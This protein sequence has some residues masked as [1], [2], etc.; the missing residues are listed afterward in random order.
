MYFDIHY[1][2]KFLRY[3]T[4]I[5]I[6]VGIVTVAVGVIL[7][8][9]ISL[10]DDSKYQAIRIVNGLKIINDSIFISGLALLCCGLIGFLTTKI[11]NDITVGLFACTSFIIFFSILLFT[12]GFI[13]LIFVNSINQSQ[14]NPCFHSDFFKN[15]ERVQNKAQRYYGSSY[16]KTNIQDMSQFVRDSEFRQLNLQNDPKNGYQSVFNCP[17]YYDMLS[18]LKIDKFDETPSYIGS[19]EITFQCA[20]ICQHHPVYVFSDINRG[21]PVYQKGCYKAVVEFVDKVSIPGVIILWSITCLLLMVVIN[22][23]CLFFHPKRYDDLYIYQIINQNEQDDNQQEENS[24]R[25]EITFNK[26]QSQASQQQ[27]DISTLDQSQH[28]DLQ[29]RDSIFKQDT[30]LNRKVNDNIQGKQQ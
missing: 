18:D 19:M 30:I 28:K 15:S 13:G 12:M 4:N 23:I 26:Q 8:I 10:E 16:C 1:I 2:R 20:G 5:L 24:I 21:L 14:S 9:F 29:G 22:S 6:V 27:I 7:T 17:H 3:T 25:E 11:N